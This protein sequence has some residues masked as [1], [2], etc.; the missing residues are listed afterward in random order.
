LISLL[1]RLARLSISLALVGAVALAAIAGVATTGW[2]DRVF[3]YF[4]EPDLDGTPATYG[5]PYEDAW[6]TTEDGVRLHG[7][8]VPAESDTTWFWFHGNA[9]NVSD[10]LDNLKQL[11]DKLG[12]NILLFD[13]R[14]YG[15]SQGTPSEKG[16]YLDGDAAIAYLHSRQ[17]VADDKIVYFG[18]SLGAAV[19][20]DIA[21]RQPP[22]GLILESP[23][24]SVASVAQHAYPALPSWLANLALQAQFDASAKI[25]N[26]SQ[27]LLVLHGNQD[28]TIPIAA[29]RQLFDNANE[30]KTFYVIENAGHNDTYVVGGERY[31]AALATFLDR[32]APSPPR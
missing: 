2:L 20:V 6:F 14:G 12:V 24:P 4:P 3:I 29:G 17:D 9:G 1:K 10:R 21:L 8:F 13:Y 25:G 18:R 26:I 7:W 5:L 11:H 15:R 32:L 19:A 16:L 22:L 31:F 30:P 27:P 23:I 28:D